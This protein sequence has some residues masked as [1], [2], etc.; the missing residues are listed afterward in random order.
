MDTS[1]E[2]SEERGTPSTIGKRSSL[3]NHFSLSSR[4]VSGVSLC[5]A[6]NL[7]LSAILSERDDPPTRPQYPPQAL[8][9]RHR[10]HRL[11][12]SPRNLPNSFL[13]SPVVD[14]HAT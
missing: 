6:L 1:Q 13:N 8:H 14:F 9:P 3:T 12:R 7:P 10:L 5:H 4:L 2:N 11:F